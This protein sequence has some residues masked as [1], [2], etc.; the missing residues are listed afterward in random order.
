M[1]GVQ[2]PSAEATAWANTQRRQTSQ[3]I[4]SVRS[5]SRLDEKRPID[6]AV[7]RV[8]SSQS[9]SANLR[10]C[11][12]HSDTSLLWT[13]IWQGSHPSCKV[14]D[15]FSLKFQ[16]LESLGKSLWSWKHCCHQ[17]SYFKAKMHQIRFWLGLCPRPY[18]VGAHNASPDP[19]A[20]FIGFYF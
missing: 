15:F 7:K 9:Y 13:C 1:A 20:G 2:P 14:L 11:S 17:M 12:L 6:I 4:R 3:L 5:F 10:F 8:K 19:L 18:A 16:D